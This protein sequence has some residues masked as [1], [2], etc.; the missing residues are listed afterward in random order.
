MGL[1]WSCADREATWAPS[2]GSNR[3]KL[4]T[5]S[6]TFTVPRSYVEELLLQYPFLATWNEYEGAFEAPNSNYG[7]IL[8]MAKQ[9]NYLKTG[10]HVLPLEGY[11]FSDLFKSGGLHT[12][13]QIPPRPEYTPMVFPLEN[14][15]PLLSSKRMVY[16]K[17]RRHT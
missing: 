9:L 8:D 4:V 11:L 12:F 10:R 5:R 3:V 15:P 17:M 2:A 1:F 14:T 6:G 13:N 7:D 16:T